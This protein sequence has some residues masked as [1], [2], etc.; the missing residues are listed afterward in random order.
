MQNTKA[1]GEIT[2]GVILAHLLKRGEVVL[3]PF[4]NNQRYDMVVDRSGLLI[5]A[6][7]KTGRL[8]QGAVSF[9]S[10][11]VS[12]V[13]GRTRHYRGDVD[14]FHVWCPELDIIYEVPTQLCGTV[15]VRLRVEQSRNGQSRNVGMPQTLNC[16]LE[17]QNGSNTSSRSLMAR[18]SY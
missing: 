2:E 9:R 6:Q 17:F 12:P 7:C 13:T 1:L 5:K 8:R 11:N 3:L 10:C 18:A 16:P 15:E 14:V 4:G